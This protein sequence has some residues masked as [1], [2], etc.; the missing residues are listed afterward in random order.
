MSFDPMVT[1]DVIVS[2]AKRLGL[3]DRVHAHEPKSA[4]GNGLTC[5]IWA[6]HIG[7]IQSSGL[8]S[9]SLRVTYSVR[10]YYPMLKEPQD[11]IDRTVLAA[12]AALMS[13][14]SGDFTLDDEARH[15]DLLGAYGVALSSQAGYL[16]QDKRLFR[17]FT[18]SLPIIFNDVFEQVA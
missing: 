15:V 14:Y 3:F 17:V 8:D 7:P 13:A 5:A 12:V 9:T 6:D 4:P 16:D 2:H 1:Q 10:L 18:I 11:A